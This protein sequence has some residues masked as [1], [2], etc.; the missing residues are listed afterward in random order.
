MSHKIK[1]NQVE[2]SHKHLKIRLNNT[3]IEHDSLEMN[4]NNTNIHEFRLEWLENQ[5]NILQWSHKSITILLKINTNGMELELNIV[6]F[7]LNQVEIVGISR[8]MSRIV[9][10]FNRTCRNKNTSPYK[11]KKRSC[12]WET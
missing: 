11:S 10:N 5:L 12:L 8:L 1:L 6:H 7:K 2:M 4:E 9:L 3:E